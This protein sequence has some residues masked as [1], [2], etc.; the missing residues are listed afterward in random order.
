[1]VELGG[2]SQ[3]KTSED[4]DFIA[5]FWQCAFFFFFLRCGYHSDEQVGMW[6]H[7]SYEVNIWCHAHSVTGEMALL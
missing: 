6:S 1:M 5:L 7:C 3:R 4:R 2:K